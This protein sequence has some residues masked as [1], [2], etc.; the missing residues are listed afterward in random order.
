MSPLLHIAPP[1]DSR[2]VAFATVCVARDAARTANY[3][4]PVITVAGWVFDHSRPRSIVQQ[5]ASLLMCSAMIDK[6]SRGPSNGLATTGGEIV[7]RLN[8]ILH[9]ACEMID[10]CKYVCVI[11]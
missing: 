3:F 6:T 5:T 11:F 10:S 1:S 7:E 8:K 9:P 2:G 4:Q